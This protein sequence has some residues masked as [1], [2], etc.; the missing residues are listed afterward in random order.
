MNLSERETLV[1]AID[2]ASQPDQQ[3]QQRAQEVHQKQIEFQQSQINALQGQGEESKARAIK[4]MVEAQAV[5]VEL[6]LDKI[7][8][9]TANLDDG[10]SDDKEF[11]RRLQLADRILKDRELEL[12]YNQTQGQP[13]GNAAPTGGSGQSS[14]SELQDFDTSDR[15][16][17]GSIRQPT[18]L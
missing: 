7:K 2:Q 6:E 13:N 11:E 17:G 5:P 8:A 9:V 14:E 3:E 12:K 18:G 1:S 16:A 10:V 15:G 4:L